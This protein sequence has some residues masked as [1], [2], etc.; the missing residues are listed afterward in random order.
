MNLEII[1]VVAFVLFTFLVLQVTR[2]KSIR[3]TE[4]RDRSVMHNNPTITG[5]DME[6][7]KEGEEKVNAVPEIS[8][9]REVIKSSK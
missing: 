4:E 7:V 1:A 8:T 9:V 3:A 6:I 2:M 5:A